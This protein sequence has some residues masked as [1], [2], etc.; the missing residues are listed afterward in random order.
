MIKM[1]SADPHGLGDILQE[2]CEKIA[3]VDGFM[4]FREL[5]NG[6]EYP[7][8]PYNDLKLYLSYE[9]GFAHAMRDAV[10]ANS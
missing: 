10:K 6:G 2:M 5:S 3:Y 7:E 4:T 9:D 1:L 8:N